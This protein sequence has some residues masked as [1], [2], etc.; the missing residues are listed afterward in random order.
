MM[1][2]VLL[3]ACLVAGGRASPAITQELVD[4]INSKQSSWTAH[5]SPRF[6]TAEMDDVKIL[7]GTVMR[8]DER[9]REVLDEKQET[10]DEAAAPIPSSFD[11]RTQWPNCASVSGHIRDQSSCGSCWAFGSTEAFNDRHCIAT[12]DTT[13]LSAED[14]VGN[15][16]FV[17]CSSMGCNGGQPGAAWRWFTTHGV[18][19]GGDYDDIG[20]GDTCGPYTLAPC[21]HHVDPSPAYPACPSSEYPT[22][23]MGSECSESQYSTS[24]SADKKKASNSYS[25]SSVEKIQRDMAQYGTV[26]AAFTV[27]ADFPTY[28]SGVYHHV[29]GSALGGHAIKMVGWGTENGEDYWIVANSWN[30][31]WGDHG[32]FKIRRGSNECGIEG[33]V[34]A[35]TFSASETVQ[36]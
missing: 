21:A 6:A 12:G 14:T 9:Y 25:L 30:D 1:R 20:K 7:C 33:Q 11:V 34:S 18:V 27:Y 4:E 23:E 22:P 28:K 8:G 16:G 15:C 26:T 5:V 19:T 2:A 35:G 36:V 3:V 32:T 10:V 24:Y 29:T 17:Q 13:F 31:Q